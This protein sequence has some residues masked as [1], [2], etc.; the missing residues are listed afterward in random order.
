MPNW[1]PGIEEPPLTPKQIA[2]ELR[3]MIEQAK[4]LADKLDPP[5]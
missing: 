1:K 2:A 4:V 3:K 5:E